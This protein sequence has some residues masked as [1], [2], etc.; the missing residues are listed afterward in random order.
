[1]SGVS[2]RVKICAAFAVLLAIVLGLGLF[3]VS[4][5]ATVNGLTTEM[6]KV[7]APSIAVTGNI[8]AALG[9][10]RNAEAQ[11]ILAVDRSQRDDAEKALGTQA[12]DLSSFR[13]RYESL[14]SEHDEQQI[15]QD[16]EK[17]LQD[18]LQIHQKILERAKDGESIAA[19]ALYFGPSHKAYDQGMADIDKL[20]TMRQQGSD[21]ASQRSDE[22]YAQV[23]IWV[24]G[25]VVVTV[26]LTV[27]LAVFLVTSI[28]APISKMTGV[29]LRLADNDFSVVVPGDGRGDELGQ[30][31]RSVTTFKKTMEDNRRLAD[32]VKEA[33]RK[34]AEQRKTELNLMAD[35]FEASVK[36]VVQDLSLAAG[37]MESSAQSMASVAEQANRQA[38]HVNAAANEASNNV[39][40]VASATT[41]LSS[42]IAEIGQ[43]VEESSRVAGGAVS[44]ASQ[45]SALVGNLAGAVERIGAV[46]NLINDIASQTNLLALNATIEAARAGEAGKGFAVVA[47]EVKSLANQTAKATDEIGQQISAVQKATTQAVS[48]IGSIAETIRHMDEISGSVAAAVEEQSA[49]TQEI[50]RNV[51]MAAVGTTQV[52]STIADV[53]KASTETGTAARQVL[54]AAQ[55][56]ATRASTLSADLDRFVTSVRR[57]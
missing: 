51:Q 18:Y 4:R 16:F 14:N 43:Q 10:F 36:V 21:A 34:A 12:N 20:T 54:D 24:L 38:A 29:M 41:Q 8:K 33:D 23:R 30:M 28:S 32:D 45:V 52:T 48:S 13:K 25:A 31:A 7:W 57:A 15:Y 55:R 6:S 11:L 27:A 44:E 42:S 22:I 5:L 56:L 2:I 49:A 46:V 35:D 47:G 40:T 50:A 26:L 3:A 37:Q 39:Q 17:S 1:M 9:N 53:S 19:T